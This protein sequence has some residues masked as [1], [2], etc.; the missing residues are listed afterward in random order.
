[1]K[2]S[3]LPL[4]DYKQTVQQIARL[5]IQYSGDMAGIFPKNVEKLY[6]Y[7][8]ALE[9]VKDNNSEL[10]Q[11]PAYTMKE[12]RG[13]CKKKAVC[14]AAWCIHNGILP[15]FIVCSTRADRQ[16]HHI[17]T[18]YKKGRKWIIADCTYNHGKLGQILQTETFSEAWEL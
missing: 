8:C 14:F 17:Y 16:P 15:R 1:M 12:G 4:I 3:V 5:S 2:K 7:L 13:D 9:Y 18:E 6:N 10:I 11:R